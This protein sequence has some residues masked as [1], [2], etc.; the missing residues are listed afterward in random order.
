VKR[1]L[2]FLVAVI[3]LVS[4]CDWGME[5]SAYD[6]KLVVFGYFRANSPLLDTVFVSLSHAIDESIDLPGKWIADA[7]VT[8]WDGETPP[9]CLQPVEGRPGRYLDQYWRSHFI[10]RARLYELAVTWGEYKVRTYT[11][12]PDTFVVRSVSSTEWSCLDQ[13][14]E[15][16]AI[17]LYDDENSQREIERALETGNYYS[18]N[19]DVVYHR[20]GLC[21]SASMASIPLFI[22]QLE[23]ESS[24]DAYMARI[25][26]TALKDDVTN[27]IIDTS[28]IANSLKGSMR[29]DESGNLFRSKTYTWS[30][31]AD[32]I[33]FNWLSFNYYGPQVVTIEVTDESLHEYLEGSVDGYNPFKPP[34]GNIEGGYGLVYSSYSYSFVVRVDQFGAQ[35]QSVA[36]SQHR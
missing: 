6:E 14:V 19:M 1:R 29:K 21:Y 24:P 3:V 7:K 18:L 27:A 20:Q 33:F 12:I 23:S 28:A 11:Q 35:P 5:E 30:S 16:P 9:F 17:N 25:T 4:G 31:G 26:T 2:L 8:L 13:P 34:G 10:H 15:V 36:Y 22:V 32:I